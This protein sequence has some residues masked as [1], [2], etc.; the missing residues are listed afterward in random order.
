MSYRDPGRDEVTLIKNKDQMF[1]G[2][3]LFQIR[4]YALRARSHGIAS[5]QHLDDDIR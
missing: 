3:L 2:F 5:I 4:L 1:P